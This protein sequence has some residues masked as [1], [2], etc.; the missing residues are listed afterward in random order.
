MIP[1]MD[2]RA[3]QAM[4]RFGLGRRGGET[5]PA[6]PRAWLADQLAGPDRSELPATL[7]STADALILLRE[8]R[9]LRPPPGSSLVEP[10]LRAEAQAQLGLLVTSPAP[11]RERLVWFWANHFTVSTR[12]NG[13]KAVV[14]AFIREAIR[15][16]VTSRFTDMLLAVMRHPAMLI[17]LDN[18]RSA[19]PD[20]V[21]GRRGHRGL[22][23]NLAR[24][25]LE[26]HTLGVGSGYGQADVTAFARILT[27]W[28]VDH[29][30]A[31]PGFVFRPD[32]H[33]PGDKTLLGRRIPEGEAGGVIALDM[34]ASHPATWRHLA[35]QLV[36]H[37]VADDPPAD[38]VARIASVLRESQGDLGQASLALTRLPG[39]WAPL[40]KFR[41]PIEYAV[42]VVRALEL[43]PDTLGAH[44]GLL[45]EL[46]QPLWSAPLPNGW[47]DRE[48]DWASAGGMLAR[49]DW[50]YALSGHA[51]SAAAAPDPIAVAEAC[52][53]PLLR[54]Q[55]RAA[56]AHAGDRRDALTLLFAAPEFQRR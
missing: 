25:C 12:Q 29:A 36:A 21:A 53:G 55:T 11:F 8:Q 5:P 24:E 26:L 39:A 14:G 42:A 2:N 27:G 17:Y 22:N 38:D 51:L 9:R 28:S 49:I 45:R 35:T 43:P 20:S 16:H 40:A 56:I 32:A 48:A 46:G 54:P 1:R 10:I 7:P 44:P 4:I 31:A 6:A 3:A 50:S 41:P 13:V 37:F 30:A 18:Q 19:G 52:L 34:L 33:Q 15:P 23:E 47:P